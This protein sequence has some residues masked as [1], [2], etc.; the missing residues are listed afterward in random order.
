MQ[1]ENSSFVLDSSFTLAWV[2]E[3]E[4]E[5]EH[6]NRVFDLLNQHSANVPSLWFYEVSNVLAI[7]ER[8]G[9]LVQKD[10]ARMIA[11]LRALPLV[12]DQDCESRSLREILA[13]ARTN[14]L[15]VYDATYLDLAMK[16]GLPLATLDTKM[17]RVAE[18]LGITIL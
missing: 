17:I 18:S 6:V 14:S 7:S 1:V 12:V 4:G 11:I 15:T 3:E 5:E 13:L 8:R 2:L 10:L 9:R 16:T